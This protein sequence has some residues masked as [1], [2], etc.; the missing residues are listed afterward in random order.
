MVSKLL[1]WRWS[2][3]KVTIPPVFLV[4]TSP[5]VCYYIM[6]IRGYKKLVSLVSVTPQHH[7]WLV[8]LCC[9]DGCG[10]E[11]TGGHIVGIGLDGLDYGLL[12]NVWKLLAFGWSTVLRN[13]LCSRSLLLV[14][15]C[16]TFRFHNVH[17]LKTLFDFIIYWL[18]L[19]MS[20]PSITNWF[21]DFLSSL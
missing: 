20:P 12:L 13:L 15:S 5:Q 14:I 17:W 3:S 19:K 8:V 11:Y 16:W 4:T 2:C 6:K 7:F 21:T 1:K 10:C 9:D 18:M